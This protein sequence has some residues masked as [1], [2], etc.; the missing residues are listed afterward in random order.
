MGEV[1]VV[2]SGKDGVGKTVVVTNLGAGLAQNGYSVVLLDMNIGSRNLDMRMGLE[3]RVVYDVADIIA[4]VCRIKKAMIKDERFENLYLISAPQRKDKAVITTAQLSA[5]CRELK[6]V[7]D[8]IIIDAPAGAGHDFLLAASPADRAVLVT[9][10]EYAAIRDSELI[11]AMLKKAGI[12]R[13]SVIVNMILPDL[14]N[15]KLVP[16]PEEI[17]ESLRLPVDGLIPYDRNIHISANMGIPI[18]AI[19]NNYIAENM[20]GI[21]ERIASKN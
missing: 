6:R 4:G 19:E 9:I 21:A 13:R 11:N 8:Y 2:A 1:I 15:T 5:L 14:H 10:P 17:S 12:S 7:F 3:D 20:K 18:V 16:D